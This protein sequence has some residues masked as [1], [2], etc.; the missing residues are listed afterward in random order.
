MN[1]LKRTLAFVLVL[2]LLLSVGGMALAQEVPDME[3]VF[4][5]DW[6]YRYVIHSFRFG[7]TTGVSA[8]GFRFMPHREV[9]RAEFITMLGRMHEYA[10]ETIGT[11]GEGS[12]Y[13]RYLD[14]AEELG[15]VHGNEYGDLMPQMTITREQ[16]A[17][18]V[19]RYI[20]VFDLDEYFFEIDLF[21]DT[22]QDAEE[23]SCWALCAVNRTF[24]LGIIRESPEGEPDKFEFLPQAD[25]SRADA[26]ATLVRMSIVLY[27]QK[28]SCCFLGLEVPPYDEYE[29]SPPYEPVPP[30]QPPRRWTYYDVNV[31]SRM[32]WG[33]GRGVTRN[34]Q[35]LIVWTALNRLENGRYGR[36][37]V[38]VVRAPRQ[39]HGYSPRFPVT[40]EIR[41]MVI[42]V[43]E[44]WDR[45]E[46]AKVYPPF[47]V[48]PNYLY[49]HGDGRHNWFRETWR[50]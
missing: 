49:F 36:S 19:Y 30:P 26:L 41:T 47:A 9:T 28:C 27:D 45:G 35:K 23:I 18:I 6:F 13:A 44:A 46:Q 8:T 33:E 42:E 39:F 38:A 22:Y 20:E 10:N 14:W 24:S 16:M 21:N 29:A 34:E 11:P 32:V 31:L 43:L 15:I 7:L 17:V 12:F 48:T 50:R 40:Q 3:D 5:D 2:C 1:R 4:P 25:V 37:I